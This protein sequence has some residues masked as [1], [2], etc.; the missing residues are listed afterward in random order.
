MRLGMNFECGCDG[1]DQQVCDLAKRLNPEIK[2]SSV[3]LGNKKLLVRDCGSAAERLL[4]QGCVRVLIVWDLYPAWREKGQR[5]CR[6]EDRQAIHGSLARANVDLA[7]VELICIQAEL[8]AWLIADGRALSLVLSTRA[9]QVRVRHA[10][11]PERTNDPKKDLM[12]IF[13]TNRRSKYSAHLHALPIIRALP[14]FKRLDRVATFVR[15]RQKIEG[16]E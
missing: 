15:F 10:R 13:Q 9:H 4:T 12:R 1:P 3:A 8:E 14:D 11:N 2:I 7:K 16:L 5:P 6:R